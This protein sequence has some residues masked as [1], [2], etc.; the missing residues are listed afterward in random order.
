MLDSK[1]PRD[2]I[3]PYK[4]YLSPYIRELQHVHSSLV[5]HV[6]LVSTTNVG[7]HAASDTRIGRYVQCLSVLGRACRFLVH[8]FYLRL[9]RS[10]ACQIR[11]LDVGWRVISSSQRYLREICIRVRGRDPDPQLWDAAIVERY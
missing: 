5:A 8:A 11:I 9:L 4:K 1:K 7:Q 10:H 3:S 2:R 6:I